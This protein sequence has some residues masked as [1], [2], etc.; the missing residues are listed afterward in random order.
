MRQSRKA[1][2]HN[3]RRRCTCKRQTLNRR[4]QAH[5]QNKVGYSSSY[6]M[7]E[8]EPG[9]IIKTYLR[10][11]L[12][13]HVQNPPWVTHLQAKALGM[14]HHIS[15]H[16]HSNGLKLEDLKDLRL[17]LSS[18]T[19]NIPWRPPTRGEICEVAGTQSV[20][21]ECDVIVN[22]KVSS[23]LYLEVK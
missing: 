23:S 19:D 21:G 22:L 15:V 20:S 7:W 2:F 14:T 17:N 4:V 8:K 11:S 3:H 10:A 6:P 9:T 18:R 13:R 5:F 12:Y 1:G 16:D